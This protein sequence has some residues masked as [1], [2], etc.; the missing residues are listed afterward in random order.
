MRIA[1][2]RNHRQQYVPAIFK[3]YKKVMKKKSNTNRQ[4]MKI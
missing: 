2:D 3:T 1:D 4:M